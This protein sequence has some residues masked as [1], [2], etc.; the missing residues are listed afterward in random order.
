LW[1]LDST[2][3]NTMH[4]Q[5]MVSLIREKKATWLDY[6]LACV[7]D[8]PIDG[9]VTL[10][11]LLYGARVHQFAVSGRNASAED[12][13]RDWLK[14]HQ[15]PLQNVFLRVD[16]DYT[17]NGLFKVKVINQLRERGFDVVLFIEDWQETADTITEKTGV[18]VLV[19]KGIYEVEGEGAV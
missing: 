1:D 12:I 3:A 14:R 5:H 8:A 17:A 16:G 6:S 18:P 9:A 7:D 2:L 4:R 11:R 10:V 15:V 19:V 13:T